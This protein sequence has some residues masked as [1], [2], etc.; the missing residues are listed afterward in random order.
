[1]DE[2]ARQLIVDAMSELERQ[3]IRQ[4]IKQCVLCRRVRVSTKTYAALRIGEC[5][6][7]D[8]YLALKAALG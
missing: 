6:R 4:S 1:M 7:L 8:V 5:N 2:H 3:R